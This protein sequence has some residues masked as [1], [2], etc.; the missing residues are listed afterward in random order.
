M[1]AG[2][3]LRG[4][5][6]WCALATLTIATGVRADLIASWNF[7]DSNLVVDQGNGTLGTNFP[8]AD[9]S[10]AAGTTRNAQPGTI[11]GQSLTLR[12]QANNATGYLN[13]SIDTTGYSGIGLSLATQRTVTGF[14]S[15][16]LSYSGDGGLSFTDFG[17]PYSP[18]TSFDLLTFD[19]G[20][21]TAIE[22]NP[23]AVFRFV[24]SGATSATGNNRLDNI[25]FTGSPVP[26]AVPEPSAWLLALVGLGACWRR[27][28]GTLNLA[29]AL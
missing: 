2:G 20:G 25:S 26:A 12:N 1:G 9:V 5:I 21:L 16:Q 10:F 29:K 18:P 17:T 14:N 22:N 7:N 13:F 28:A 11:A 3:I 24:F 8:A 4:G 23:G 6:S 27:F 15:N 19:F